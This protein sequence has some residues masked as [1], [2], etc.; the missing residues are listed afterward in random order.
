MNCWYC[1][2]GEMIWG[3]DHD[4]EDDSPFSFE[5]SFTCNNE[6][7]RAEATFYSRKEE[8]EF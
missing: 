4:I 8:D 1:R 5:T 2:T 7:C 6:E 3:G